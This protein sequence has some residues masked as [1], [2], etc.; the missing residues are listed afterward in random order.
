VK[1][2]DK[3][4]T[5]SQLKKMSSKMFGG[6]VKAVID[7][8]KEIMVVDGALHSD[9]EKHLLDSGSNQNDLWGINLYPDE[10]DEDFIE[11][12]SIINVR[13]RLNNL[14]REVEDKLIRKKIIFIVN[15]L[16]KK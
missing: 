4:I 15:K 3:I 8:K 11:Y 9:E 12:D 2:I 5:I 16:V 1:L 14:S 13:P 7:I 6:I 10:K